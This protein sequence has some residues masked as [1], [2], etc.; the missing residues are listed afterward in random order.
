[1]LARL[2]LAFF[3]G[4]GLLLSLLGSSASLMASN[5]E[6]APYAPQKITGRV[7]GFGPLPRDDVID[8][9]VVFSTLTE[10]QILSFDF[11]NLLSPNEPLKAGPQTTQVPG[12]VFVPR[13][14]ERYGWF[15]ITI[16]KLSFSVYLEPQEQNEL[17]VI[18][19]KAPFNEAIDKA[20]KKAPM[21]ELIRL[22]SFNKLGFASARDWSKERSPITLNL[23][24]SRPNSLS[25]AWNRPA[26]S[27][28]QSD[29]VLNFEET[30][31]GRWLISDF[32]TRPTARMTTHSTSFNGLAKLMLARSQFDQ[33]ND[34]V[35]MRSW[36]STHSKTGSVAAEGVPSP[37]GSIAWANAT[38]LSWNPAGKTGWVTVFVEESKKVHADELVPE[39]M[40]FFPDLSR[41]HEDL[42]R[43]KTQ[44]QWVRVETGSL[45]LPQT[46][47]AK[48]DISLVFLGGSLEQGPELEGASELHVY[49]VSK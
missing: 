13:Q 31:M 49:N 19:A 14:S 41:I 38:T 1:M 26:P 16:E 9:S 30:P 28:S 24:Q 29:I 47:K 17:F 33:N 18:A 45:Q 15:P 7:D 46:P 11:S 21:P 37:L 22:L 23:S 43:I 35:E 8:L 34:F 27:N 20:R 5:N 48:A 10:E 40:I 3:L 25:V 44:T 39:E 2:F 12:N 32:N 4:L 42:S 6:W 36:F